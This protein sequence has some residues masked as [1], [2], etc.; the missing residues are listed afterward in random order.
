MRSAL[1]LARRGLG[2]VWPNP[3]VG[4][5]LVREA[6]SGE[7]A[8]GRA[9]RVVGRGWT[10][11]GG[12]PHAETEAIRR[13]GADTKGT[14]AYVT[15]EPCAHHGVTPPCVDALIAAR[16]ARV[17][18][19]IDDPDSR[20]AGRGLARLKESGIEVARGVGAA[21]AAEIN[22]GFFLRVREGRPLVTLKL[23][24]TLDG[25]IAAANGESR[26]VTGTEARARAHRLR[27]EFDAVM[28]GSGAARVDDPEL[29]CRLPG[30]AGRQPVRIVMNGR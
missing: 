5:V 17:V 1:A 11:P 20:T 12:R 29:T 4:C 24:S 6:D 2:N 18:A 21:E 30:F 10:Q 25:R 3:A 23:A 19:A 13:A 14:T 26:W 28:I 15:L 22:A 27:A 16:V 9:G 7:Q 8:G